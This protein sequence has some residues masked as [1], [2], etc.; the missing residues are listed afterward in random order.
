MLGGKYHLLGDLDIVQEN[1][2]KTLVAKLMDSFSM[3]KNATKVILPPLPR[4]VTGA[5]C[6]DVGHAH[7]SRDP[8]KSLGL[9]K[10]VGGLRKILKEMVVKSGV[11]RVWIPDIMGGLFGEGE[12]K[13][14]NGK[15]VLSGASGIFSKDNVHLSNAGFEKLTGM[16][17]QGI[18]RI[19]IKKN[20]AA[21]LSNAGTEKHYWRGFCS[22]RGSARN[23]HQPMGHHSRGRGGW[24]RGHR[25]G[26][27]EQ[28]GHYGQHG[29]Q[30][31]HFRR[32]AHPYRRQ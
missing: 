24:M 27:H 7:N 18:E 14:L 17:L 31:Q 15:D 3:E 19:S 13:G 23:P 1:S 25:G 22:D 30:G 32:G 2:F 6:D 5:C 10:K 21:V 11:E 9:C 4:Y 20:A 12:G 26:Q 16:I 28:P 29:L 8:V